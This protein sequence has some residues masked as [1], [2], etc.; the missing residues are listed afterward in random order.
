MA[1][2]QV[3][4][5]WRFS[6]SIM[7]AANAVLLRPQVALVGKTKWQYVRS[8]RTRSIWSLGKIVAQE[9]LTPHG[10]ALLGFRGYRQFDDSFCGR[11]NA[12]VHPPAKQ[13]KSKR[14]LSYVVT[15]RAK[16]SPHP[17]R[18]S[19]LFAF[20]ICFVGFKASL[21]VCSASQ[22]YADADAADMLIQ[23]ARLQ[24]IAVISPSRIGARGGSHG[25]VEA[26]SNSIA[27]RSSEL[28]DAH[29]GAKRSI[30]SSGPLASLDSP[31]P[32]P[33]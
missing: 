10:K 9:A 5:Q 17:V 25:F 27:S 26:F 29:P 11:H 6:D 21:L 1:L 15:V 2:N 20:P 13:Q 30:E 31:F 12:C 24:I 7:S 4:R 32:E 16:K 18:G 19:G 22:V 14:S 3:H 28:I 33:A 23:D 8:T